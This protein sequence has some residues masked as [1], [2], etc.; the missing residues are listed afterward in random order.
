ML[1]TEN[2]VIQG[3]HHHD[4]NLDDIHAP[5][6]HVIVGLG[7]KEIRSGSLK[8]LGLQI[9]T[10]PMNFTSGKLLDG[11]TNHQIFEPSW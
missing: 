4:I 6:G 8:R 1:F 2:F 10:K 9:L 11:P 3:D 7:L 5:E